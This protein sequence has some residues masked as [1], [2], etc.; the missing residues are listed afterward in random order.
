MPERKERVGATAVPNAKGAAIMP[1]VQKKVLP[2]ETT[3]Y[4]EECRVYNNSP[5]KAIATATFT[6][7]KKPNVADDICT[8]T[9]ESFWSLLKRVIAGGLPF[10]VSQA[11]ARLLKRVLLQIQPPQG[12]VTHVRHD[13]STSHR[14]NLTRQIPCSSMG[15]K[16]G[17]SAVTTSA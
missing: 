13:A 14:I 12:R 17:W 8:N 1:H 15:S 9:V 7:P 3:V 4:T 10:G 11:L 16:S 6:T 2:P 5:K